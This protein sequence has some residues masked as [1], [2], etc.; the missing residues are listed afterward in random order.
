M[1][2]FQSHSL[3][4]KTEQFASDDHDDFMDSDFGLSHDLDDCN[5]TGDQMSSCVFSKIF[6]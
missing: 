4:V 6:S 2:I 5:E 1:S 3:G